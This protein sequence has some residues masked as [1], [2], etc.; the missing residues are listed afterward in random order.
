MF[1]SLKKKFGFIPLD[2]LQLWEWPEDFPAQPFAFTTARALEIRK[3]GEDHLLHGT[4][5]KGDYRELCE[6]VV[7]YLGGQVSYWH[8]YFGFTPIVFT[9]SFGSF[10]KKYK[11]HPNTVYV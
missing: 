4:F 5:A 2:N 3:W 9:S 7:H 8:E 6:L 10:I 1:V 11:M